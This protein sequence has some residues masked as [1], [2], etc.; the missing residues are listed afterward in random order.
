MTKFLEPEQASK[1]IKKLLESPFWLPSLNDDTLPQRR[2]HD[3]TDGE[4][5]QNIIVSFDKMGDA[6]I[7]LEFEKLYVP[8]LRFRTYGGGG[9]SQRTRNALIILAEAMRLDNEDFKHT[10]WENKK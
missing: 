1:Q 7:G 2:A 5:L 6:Y 10:G 9:L 8:W 4:P 3:D